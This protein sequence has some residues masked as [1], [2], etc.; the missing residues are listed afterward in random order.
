M[1]AFNTVVQEVQ[2]ILNSK[3]ID[4]LK[5]TRFWPLLK[6]FYKRSMSNVDI[7]KSDLDLKKDGESFQPSNQV[8]QLWETKYPNNL[9]IS[10][11]EG[12]GKG[13]EKSEDEYEVVDFKK[14]VVVSILLE[15]CLTMLFSNSASTLNWKIMEYCE[16]LEDLS[17][18]SWAKFFL[19]C[20]RTTLIQPMIGKESSNDKIEP[21]RTP[22]QVQSRRECLKY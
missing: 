5:K 4:L 10:D 18:Y 22:H 17:K 21:S 20:E 9:Q 3:Q 14:D 8:N 19:L 16:K 13:K 15:L 2:G 12:K 7:V 6:A 1:T 11:E